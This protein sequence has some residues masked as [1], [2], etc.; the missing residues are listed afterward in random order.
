MQSNW[1]LQQGIFR[2]VILNLLIAIVYMIGVALSHQ[3]I[4]LPGT[5][6]SVWF[7]SGITLA[8]VFWFGWR[9]YVGI[10][11]GS[12]LAILFSLLEVHP[13]LSLFDLCLIL[14]ACAC[15]NVLQ[16]L[17]AT[18]IIKK[19]SPHRNIF[20]HVK[21]VVLYIGAAVI[22]PMVSATF[23]I[24]S[25]CIS[26]IITWKDYG[27]SWLTWWLASAIAHLIFTPTLLLWKNFRKN[28]QRQNLAEIVG[29]ISIT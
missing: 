9:V 26:G 17:L 16:P 29:V 13:P 7:P 25:L 23:G 20:S 15:G 1:L 21:S 8:L 14:I 10:I 4:T 28:Y 27:I 2:F 22:S 24:T 19:F 6:A 18:H 5:V 12:T 11:C 3:L